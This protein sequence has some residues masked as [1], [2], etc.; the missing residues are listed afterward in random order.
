MVLLPFAEDMI[1]VPSA[2]VATDQGEI[3]R[4]LVIQVAPELV[5]A[6]MA[7]P[8][9]NNLLPSAETLTKLDEGKP[10]GVHVVPEFVER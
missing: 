3:E 10:Q 8:K 2:E 4:L 7:E 5:E 1:F 6:N 9:T